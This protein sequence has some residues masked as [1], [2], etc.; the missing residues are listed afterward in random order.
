MLIL[1]ENIGYIDIERKITDKSLKSIS[2]I[3]KFV[4]YEKDNTIF[5]CLGKNKWYDKNK[6]KNIDFSVCLYSENCEKN[7]GS[8][9][10]KVLIKKKK[11]SNQL[12]YNL[13]LDETDSLKLKNKDVAIKIGCIILDRFKNK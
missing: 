9:N 12:S 1:E 13:T 2:G 7:I 5:G 6:S 11:P 3:D 10:L 8:V 4:I